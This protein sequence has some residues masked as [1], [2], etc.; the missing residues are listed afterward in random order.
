MPRID[1]EEALMD[2][3]F[4]PCIHCGITEFYWDFDIYKCC[5]CDIVL[6]APKTPKHKEKKK[7]RKFKEE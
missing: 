1:Y 2:E 4:H 6:E 7:L 3:A 5:G